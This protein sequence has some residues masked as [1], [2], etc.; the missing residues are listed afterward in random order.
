[1]IYQVPQPVAWGYL[2]PK[3]EGLVGAQFAGWSDQQT[4]RC[5]VPLY[6]EEQLLEAFEAGKKS[7]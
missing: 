6:T 1:M 3:L 4:R 7:K 2:T 5:T